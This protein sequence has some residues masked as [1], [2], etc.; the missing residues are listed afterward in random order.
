ME[1]KKFLKATSVKICRWGKKNAPEIL[2]TIGIVG[3]GAG[4]VIAVRN[5]EKKVVPRKQEREDKIDSVAWE[6]HNKVTT[7]EEAAAI[8][9]KEN[10][11]CTIDVVKAYALPALVEVGGIACILWSNHESRKRIAGL[12]AAVTTISTAFDQYRERVRDRYGEDIERSIYLGEKQVEIETVDEKGKKKKEKI[13][14]ADPNIAG[15]TK[16]LT[17]ASSLW[18]DSDSFMDYQL[19]LIQ[20][21]LTDMFR[22]DPSGFMTWNTMLDEF[23]FKKNGDGLVL[24]QIYDYTKHAADN[25]IDIT[26]TKCKIPDE[27]GNYDDAWRIEFPSLKQI[28]EELVE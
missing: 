18:S 5:T 21:K 25:Y 15:T 6:V 14:V 12:A 1:V 3:M 4:T 22:A 10:V 7:E 9:K 26:W 20:S 2:M 27:N 23:G 17:K 24:G 28:Y 19:Q 16:Y 11:A 8:V 13:T